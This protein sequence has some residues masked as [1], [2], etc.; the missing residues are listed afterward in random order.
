MVAV[1]FALLLVTLCLE[2]I[3]PGVGLTVW[4]VLYIYWPWVVGAA[5]A[6]WLFRS[7]SAS[8]SLRPD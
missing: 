3:L 7:L 2:L 5:V 1:F 8:K 6:Y 4:V